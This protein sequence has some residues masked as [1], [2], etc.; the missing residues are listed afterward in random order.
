MFQK[1]EFVSLCQSVTLLAP[2]S[3]AWLYSCELPSLKFG[4][5]NQAAIHF[6]LN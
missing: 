6:D 5:W 1:G 2:V 4:G 3:A